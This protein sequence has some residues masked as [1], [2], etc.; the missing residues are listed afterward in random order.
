MLQA[1]DTIWRYMKLSTFLLLLDGK[2][3]LPSIA[4]LQSMD[5]LEGRLGDDFYIELCSELARQVDWN[6]TEK[7]LRESLSAHVKTEIQRKDG[8]P[9]YA[10]K[11]I[12]KAYTDSLASRRVAWCWFKSVI[13]SAAMWHQY[14]NRGIAVKTTVD[15]LASSFTAGK[16][17]NIQEMTYVNRDSQSSDS[18]KQLI[19]K[20]PDLLLRPFFLKAA[21]YLHEGEVR[22]VAHCPPRAAGLLVEGIKWR[23]MVNEIIISPLVPIDES[24][25]LKSSLKKVIQSDEIRISQSDM[26]GKNEPDIGDRIQNILFSTSDENMELLKL[27]ALLRNL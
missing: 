23:K 3:W 26:N 2:A 14:G 25:S 1:D 9:N 12:A 5:P 8:D 16:E 4:N 21:E 18:I 20:Q 27:P 15:Q 22:L 13:E 7:W 17:I 11:F 19:Q 6:E 24:E 10:S